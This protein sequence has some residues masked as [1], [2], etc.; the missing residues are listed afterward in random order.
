MKGCLGTLQMVKVY[1]Q[2]LDFYYL[3]MKMR[4]LQ[5][6]KIYLDERDK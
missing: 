4:Q 5:K 6:K 3:S 1:H 2:T